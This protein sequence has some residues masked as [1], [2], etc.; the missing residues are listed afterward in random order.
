MKANLLDADPDLG[1]HLPLDSVRALQ[2]G[3]HADVLQLDP[4]P[5]IPPDAAPEPG[6]L[7]YLILS[8]MLVRRVTVDRSR[9]GELLAV[10]DL[11]RPWVEDP[12]SFC[13][14]D[15]RAMETSRLAIL[16][17]SVALRLCA[18]P[19]LNAA[20]LDKQMERS[21]SLAINAATEN[22]RGLDTRLLMLFWHLAERWG[23]R[24]RG[25]VIV[26]LRLTHET[27]SLLVGA[28]R[29]SVTSALQSLSE[30][31]DLRRRDNGDWVL[32]GAPPAPIRQE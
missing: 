24:E 13:D 25:Q 12:V 21:R 2:A 20:L 30:N 22:I 7:G 26:P 28:R 15:W 3:L 17:R 10:G 27:L 6:H 14:A 29:P 19:E 31:G 4:G 32:H 5:W 18:R 1:R 9:T 11:I 8:G 16:D 23:R